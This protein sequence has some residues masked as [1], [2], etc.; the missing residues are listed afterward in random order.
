MRRP[1]FSRRVAVT[2]LG[3]ISPVGQDVDTVWD[4][5]VNG[6]SGL[7]KISR[8]DAEPYEAQAAGEID[9]FDGTQWMDFK[10]IR[11]TD[12]NVV[13]GVAAARQALADSGLEVTDE[14]RD[15]IGVIFGSGGGGPLLLMENRINWETK[16]PRTVSPFFIANMLP[17]TASGQIAIETGIR[18]SNMCIVT[19]CST[20]THNIGEAAEGIRRGDF[21]AAVTGATENPLHELVHIGFS[22]M[23]GMGTPR[24][25]EP[26][27]T[28]SRPF[29]KTRNGFVLGEG[30]GGMIVED[31]EFAKA[32]GAKIYAEV[33]GYG[34]AAD[35][36]DLIQPVE[37]GDGVRR[38]MLQALERH[39][40]P[41]D[42]V[43]LINPH[44]T[45]TPLGDLREAQ[46]IWAV[47]GD[48][49][50]RI[51]ISATKSMTGHLMGAA[52]AFEGVATVLS[53]HHQ[54]APA[55]LNY[56]DEDPEINLD[57]VA[58]SSREMEIRYALSDNIG[59][60]GHNGA[61]IFKR[62]DGD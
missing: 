54:V 13:M 43:D 12:R 35:A 52:G 9:D 18:G 7:K 41:A 8:W 55:T 10:A 31:L 28:I 36:W 23:R 15:D 51:A 44:G 20:G 19:A 60:G 33:V 56:R 29:D 37:K 32:R 24:P 14:N 61:V 5:L 45:S 27:Q 42:E 62:Y 1:D 6:R 34:S 30:A 3:V 39:G 25:G 2:G 40:V 48:H 17:D 50:P 21:I 26:L 16:G 47:F 11:R 59:L 46:A 58:G 49:T 4:S 22:N 57:I 53:V 38:A